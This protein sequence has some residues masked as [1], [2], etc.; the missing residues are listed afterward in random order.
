MSVFVETCSFHFHG[1]ELRRCRSKFK[2]ITQ[3]SFNYVSLSMSLHGACCVVSHRRIAAN[4]KAAF[5]QMFMN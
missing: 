3:R 4:R 5:Q 1:C 2:D